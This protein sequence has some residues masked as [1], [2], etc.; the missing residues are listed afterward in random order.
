MAV[1]TIEAI[2]GEVDVEVW[3]GDQ[4]ALMSCTVKIANVAQDVH[5][6]TFL[7]QVRAKFTSTDVISTLDVTFATD[8]TDGVIVVSIAADQSTVPAKKYK[9]DLQW[10]RATGDVITLLWGNF[11]VK[12]DASRA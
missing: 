1:T 7:S 5:L 2:P 8:G 11:T 6:D 9:W 3:R 12:G 10:T 4:R